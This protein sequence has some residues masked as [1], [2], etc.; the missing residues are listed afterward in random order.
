M[1]KEKSMGLDLISVGE[2][3]SHISVFNKE[4]ELSC[5]ICNAYGITSLVKI[6]NVEYKD[7]LIVLTLED[8]SIVNCIE[9]RMED[10]KD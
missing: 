8:G 2:D 9:R 10:E 3:G 7:S 5:E 1:E 6:K 4:G